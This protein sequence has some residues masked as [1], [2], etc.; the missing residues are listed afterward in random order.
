MKK[1]TDELKILSISYE[2]KKF[3]FKFFSCEYFVLHILLLVF[4]FRLV[5][6]FVY[7]IVNTRINDKKPEIRNRQSRNL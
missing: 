1:E 7:S 5:Y 2:E 4:V 6:P 3:P